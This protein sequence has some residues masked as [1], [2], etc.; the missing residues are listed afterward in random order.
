MYYVIQKKKNKKHGESWV[1]K[2]SGFIVFIC[3]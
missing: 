3:K 1:E 2:K